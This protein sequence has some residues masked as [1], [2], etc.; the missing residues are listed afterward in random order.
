MFL[1]VPKLRFNTF[2][3]NHL[4]SKNSQCLNL[5]S[6]K[7]VKLQSLILAV[8]FISIGWIERV[9]GQRE[10]ASLTQDDFNQ[11]VE[12][13]KQAKYSE[14]IVSYNKVLAS[15]DTMRFAIYNRAMCKI[16]L[17][18]FEGA[19]LDFNKL[20]ELDP[21]ANK[22]YKYLGFIEM[23]TGQSALA[24]KAFSKAIAIEPKDKES[25]LNRAILYL[26]NNEIATALG[27]FNKAI[28]IDP[29][30]EQAY[31][32]RGN[33]K[34]KSGDPGGAIVDFSIAIRMNPSNC[35]YYINRGNAKSRLKDFEAAIV[36]YNACLSKEPNN[37]LALKGRAYGLSNMGD[38]KGAIKD[39]DLQLAY[40]PKDWEAFKNRA[41]MK[42]NNKDYAGGLS[43]IRIV[44]KLYSKD[45]NLNFN[46]GYALFHLKEYNEA[47]NVFDF[48]ISKEPKNGWAYYYRAFSKKGERDEISDDVCRDLTKAAELGVSEAIVQLQS[49][50]Q[51]F[52]N[53]KK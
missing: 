48:I 42:I 39:Y 46:K 36:D 17:R 26:K 43:D 1:V 5:F 49:G 21:K 45:I 38:D 25:I 29:E 44:E 18:D 28:E 32:N 31:F 11:G 6:A 9:S 34:A 27:E 10:L 23:K 40:N 8:I 13:F 15:N 24:I 3:Q 37:S 16:N 20:L 51:G 2:I 19:K 12:M 35:S 30:F 7:S 52:V 50:C 47:K 22:A 4:H 53:R 33:A 41:I 14:A